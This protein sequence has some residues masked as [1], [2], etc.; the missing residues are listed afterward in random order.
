[1]IHLP[2][3]ANSNNSC[4]HMLC[5]LGL[6]NSNTV[7]ACLLGNNCAAIYRIVISSTKSPFRFLY[8]LEG[9][10]PLPEPMLTYHNMCSRVFI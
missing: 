5:Y 1:M 4:V 3:N 8:R 2:C 6:D 10:K 7:V 9:T